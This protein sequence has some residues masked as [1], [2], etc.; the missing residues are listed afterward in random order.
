M[1]IV[2]L[3]ILCVMNSM[4]IFSV[5]GCVLMFRNLLNVIVGD[6]GEFK[7]GFKGV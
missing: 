1:C 5:I 4:W 6:E 7:M 3:I 2:G